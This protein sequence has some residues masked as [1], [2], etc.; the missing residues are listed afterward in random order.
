MDYQSIIDQYYP[1]ENELRRI[2]LVH[3]RQVADRCL[4]IAKAH[5]ELNL[6]TEFL[7]ES[8]MLHDIGI[9][10]CNAPGIQCFGEA[11]YIQHGI[12]GAE[13]LR[14]MKWERHARVCERHTGTGLTKWDIEQ[15]QLPLPHQDYMPVEL[16]EQVVCYADKFYSKTHPGSERTVVEAMRSLEKFGWD[17]VKRVQKWV[18]LFE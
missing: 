5:P 2:L 11:P 6:D 3:S 14:K 10:G 8:A 12:I 16:E 7:E 18:D 9:F 4:K 13:I 17:G 1:E 15:Q